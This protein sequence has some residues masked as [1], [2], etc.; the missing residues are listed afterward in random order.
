MPRALPAQP[1][2]HPRQELSPHDTPLAAGTRFGIEVIAWIAGPWAVAQ[3]TG[4]AIAAVVAAVVLV[5]VPAV[6]STPGDKNVVVVP[7]PGRVRIAIELALVLAALAAS[8]I[9][10]PFWARIPIAVLALAMLVTNGPRMRALAG[11]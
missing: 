9:V 10:W 5:G 6:F 8:A 2:R 11:A 4:S 3:L 1:T 7:T